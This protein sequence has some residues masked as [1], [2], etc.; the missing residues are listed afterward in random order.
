[1][2]RFRTVIAVVLLCAAPLEA[3]VTVTQTMTIEGGMAAMMGNAMPRMVTRIKRLASRTDVE[4]MDQTIATIA[5]LAAPQLIVMNSATRTAQI[6]DAGSPALS[7]ASPGAVPKVD[8]TFTRTGQSRVIDG[9]QC[10]EHTFTMSLNMADMG[11]QAPMPSEATSAMKDV[12]MA[13][14]GSVWIAT[15]GPGVADYVSFQKAAADANMI[16][17]LT[18]I[19]P[20]QQSGG[21]DRL[22]A[23]ASAAPGLP[24]LTEMTISFEGSGKVVEMMKQVGAIKLTQRITSVST[25]PI[26]D[27]MFS[28]PVEYKIV[29]Q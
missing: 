17:A 15:S 1:M 2:T 8:M 10:E 23:A 22:I 6:F 29:K 5:D 19:R 13:M 4:V 18:G 28:V 7:G 20:G 24:Y 9:A 25:D 14:S 3:D 11:A 12:R 26:P 21:L 27:E 16:A